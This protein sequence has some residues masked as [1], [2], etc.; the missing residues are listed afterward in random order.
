MLTFL[1]KYS[2]NIIVLVVLFVLLFCCIPYQ[3]S[4]YLKQDM[5]TIKHKSRV[6]LLWVEL[7]LFV[8]VMVSQ[9]RQIRK[10]SDFFYLLIGCCSI[11]LTFFFLFSTIFLSAAYFLNSFSS[12]TTVYKNYKV[13]SVDKAHNTLLIWDMDSIK[14]AYADLSIQRI[15]AAQVKESDTV[16]VSFKK[17]L[18][19]FNFDPRI[20]R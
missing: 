11:G 3:E 17:G 4:H 19:G 13:I 20:K 14:H 2:I 6:A 9:I 18:L 7:G 16:V 15:E 8:F 12:N 10:L 5:E 1:K